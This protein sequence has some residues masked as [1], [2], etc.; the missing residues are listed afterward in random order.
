MPHNKTIS[1]CLAAL[2]LPALACGDGD[3]SSTADGAPVV[4]ADA[5]PS[6]PDAAPVLPAWSVTTQ[7]FGAESTSSY[8]LVT[9][10]LEGNTALTLDDAVELPG[11]SIGV[12]L[13]N[14]AV[15]VTG[16]EGPTLTRYNEVDGVLS[17]GETVSFANQG[18]T[19]IG[20]YG[21]QFHFRS[22]TVSYFFDSQTAQI[23]VWNPQEM[24]ITKTI[25]LPGLAEP[26]TI[27]AFSQSP[28]IE[29]GDMLYMPVGWRSSDNLSIISK[30]AVVALDMSDDSVVIDTDERCGYV[31]EAAEG[32]DGFIYI[33]TEVYGAAAFAVNNE[34]A[35]APCALRY[36]PAQKSFDDGFHV[37]LSSLV[38]GSVA[39]SFVPG[40]SNKA[41]VRALDETIAN[42]TDTTHPRALS[43]M[44]VWKWYE[45]TLGDTPTATEVTA[46]G[47][48]G[49]SVLVL[50][51]GDTLVVPEFAADFSKTNFRLF[52]DGVV[53]EPGLEMP[54]LVF[55][56][57]KLR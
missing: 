36:D 11:R 4:T 9:D 31:R 47:H 20:E 8:V 49:G 52:E 45:E 12:G 50:D 53:S 54:G 27:M 51:A 32:D 46:L 34:A 23:I 2:L 33:A 29:D 21:T 24:T 40:P 13:G 1:L 18:L 28:M 41:Y 35:P 56:L 26:D 42:I 5:D 6:A 55:S 48:S 14:Q 19:S 10:S 7:V 3:G 15:F 16:D 25:E 38:G 17:E 57:S 44:P 22:A 37:E 39:G 43:G 30:A